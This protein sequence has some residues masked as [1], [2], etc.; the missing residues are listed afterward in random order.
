[1]SKFGSGI[2]LCGYWTCQKKWFLL[3]FWMRLHKLSKCMGIGQAMEGKRGNCGFTLQ[4]AELLV[5]PELPSFYS[6]KCQ[7]TDCQP[8]SYF[9]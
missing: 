1:M 5:H 3:Y 2:F 4:P 7:R 6:L 9:I 8:L